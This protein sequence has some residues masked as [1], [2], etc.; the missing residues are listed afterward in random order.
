MA[1]DRGTL[2]RSRF[3]T[4]LRQVMEEQASSRADA[5]VSSVGEPL[6]PI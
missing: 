3:R 4:A 1:T 5:T 6:Q 2:A